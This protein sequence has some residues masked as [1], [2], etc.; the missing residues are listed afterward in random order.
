[1]HF[2]NH[3]TSISPLTKKTYQPRQLFF[4]TTSYESKMDRR[5]KYGTW[6]FNQ[7][8]HRKLWKDEWGVNWLYM[9]IICWSFSSLW[10]TFSVLTTFSASF[11][12]FFLEGFH[13]Y[14]GYRVLSFFLIVRVSHIV[15]IKSYWNWHIICKL[16]W[17]VIRILTQSIAY[18]RLL[19]KVRKNFKDKNIN[20]T[21]YEIAAAVIPPVL[22]VLL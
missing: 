21:F 12:T 17:L 10:F 22:F 3:V 15:V 1:M 20:I 5:L 18:F 14:M 8:M 19:I 2:Y 11:F 13:F 4:S 6:F 7:H 16:W 9:T